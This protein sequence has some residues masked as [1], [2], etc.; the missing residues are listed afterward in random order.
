[1]EMTNQNSIK[2]HKGSLV[3]MALAQSVLIVLNARKAK[4]LLIAE[5]ALPQS[6][7]QAFRK[8]FLN[9]FGQGGLEGELVRVITE[10]NKEDRHGQE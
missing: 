5:A 8:L 1:M 2:K 9:E 7:Y 4:V 10:S 3:M 6:Q